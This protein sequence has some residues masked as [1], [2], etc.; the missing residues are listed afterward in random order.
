MR[1]NAPG[2]TKKPVPPDSSCLLLIP[3]TR[4]TLKTRGVNVDSRRGDAAA[5]FLLWFSS[6]ETLSGC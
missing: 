4:L 2:I 5:W 3:V 6:R 1:A